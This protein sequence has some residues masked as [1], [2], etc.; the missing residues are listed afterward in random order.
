MT[1][2]QEKMVEGV[3][4][5]FMDYVSDSA[6]RCLL[7]SVPMPIEAWEKRL[8]DDFSELFTDLLAD[9]VNKIVRPPWYKRFWKWLTIIPKPEDIL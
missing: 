8:V 7:N 9:T 3:V 4:A 1:R 2:R 5:D 6:G